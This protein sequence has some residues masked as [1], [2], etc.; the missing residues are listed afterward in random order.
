MKHRHCTQI[1]LLALALLLPF[2]AQAMSKDALRREYAALSE[3]FSEDSPYRETPDSTNFSTAGSLTEAATQ[4]ALDLVNLM[5]RLAGLNEVSIDPLYT[6]RAQ[7]AA[8]VLA[9]ND[10]LSHS[11]EAPDGISED[12]YRS[13]YIGASSANIAKFNWMHSGILLDGVKYFARDDGEIN[14]S[15]LGHRRWLLDPQLEKTGFGLANAPS[16]NSFVAMYVLDDATDERDW[17]YVAWPTAD[18]FPTEWM[19]TDLAWSVSI[20][21]EKYDLAASEPTVTLTEETLGLSFRFDVKAGTGDGYCRI[22]EEACGS[23]ACLI[24][25]PDFSLCD[26][27]AYEQNQIWN[28]RVEN[29]LD[30]KGQRTEIVYRCEMVSLYP[31][32]VANV[33]ISQLSAELHTGETLTLSARVIPAYADDLRVFWSSSDPNIATVDENGVVRAIAAGQCEIT[34][35][36]VNGR[37]DRCIVKV[38]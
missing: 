36:G 37:T 22:S 8:L 30:C 18:A 21:D 3:R 2:S 35:S 14:L 33:E 5:R 29:L 12:I 25:R 26:F 1:L 9:G 15:V 31:Q 4:N 27:D 23:G 20:N 6:L 10:A 17:D 32:D 16:G 28:V 19:Q 38:Q 11:P 13:G 7:N 34:V 24:F